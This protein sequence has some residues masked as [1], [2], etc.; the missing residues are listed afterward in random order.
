[1]SGILTFSS[2]HKANFSFLEAAFRLF[3]VTKSFGIFIQN[4]EFKILNKDY[5]SI[6][7]L[8]FETLKDGRNSELHKI[9]V[10]LPSIV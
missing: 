4:L 7:N 5:R 6:D 1:M 2:S 8:D 3:F 9:Q 10:I